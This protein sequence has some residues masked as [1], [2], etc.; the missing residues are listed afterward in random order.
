MCKNVTFQFFILFLFFLHFC[1][2]VSSYAS[3]QISSS[4]LSWPLPSLSNQER[5]N[6]LDFFTKNQV[7]DL[8]NKSKNYEIPECLSIWGAIKKGEYRFLAP[9]HP[10][11]FEDAKKTMGFL[12]CPNFNPGILHHTKMLGYTD[13]ENQPNEDYFYKFDKNIELY[14][15]SDYFPQNKVWGFFA[16]GGELNCP[17]NNQTLCDNVSDYQKINGVTSIVFSSSE[18]Q[19]FLSGYTRTG[20]RLTP[21]SIIGKS[22]PYYY[23]ETAKFRGMLEIKSEPYRIQVNAPELNDLGSIQQKLNVKIIVEAVNPNRP[24][25]CEFDAKK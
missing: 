22:P 13:K 15:L 24:L 16:E 20:S 18:C 6:R 3:D 7:Y 25:K 19:I 12:S 8:S 17:K 10:T 4:Q 23:N 14:N 2:S 21:K 5:N 11:G 9:T 1:F